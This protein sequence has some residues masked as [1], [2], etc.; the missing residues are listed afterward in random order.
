MNTLRDGLKP[1]VNKLHKLEGVWKKNWYN[2]HSQLLK[3]YFDYQLIACLF[4]AGS[5]EVKGFELKGMRM[6][7]VLNITDSK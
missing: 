5:A 6:D 2:I 3:Q 4:Y 1:K 7:E